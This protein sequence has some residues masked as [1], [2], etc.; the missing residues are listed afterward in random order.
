MLQCQD[1]QKI[2]TLIITGGHDFEREAFFA[3]FDSFK[4]VEYREIIHPEANQ[5]YASSMLDSVDVLVFYDMVQDISEEQKTE[6]IALL[7]KGKSLLFLHH[8]LVSYQEWDEF[9]RIIGGKYHLKQKGD[10]TPDLPESNYKHDMEFQV[11]IADKNHPITRGLSDFMIHDEIYGDYTVLP[12]VFPLL[13][14]DHPESGEIVGWINH[15]KNSWI[16]YIQSG[17]DHLA[18]ENPNYR[19]LL[20]QTIR[21]L[22]DPHSY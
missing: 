9:T 15:Y 2:K 1:N 3:L 19:R 4:D 17:H 7:E 11:R 14:T 18:Y 8:S 10:E 6:F 13:T 20:N 21:W 12:G 22:A 16:V 5:A